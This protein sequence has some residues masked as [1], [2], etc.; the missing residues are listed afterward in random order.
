MLRAYFRAPT[1]IFLG[2]WLVLMLAGR[3]RFF[4]DPGAMWHIVV[5]QHI[6]SQHE[7]PHTDPFS[8][9]F[10]GQ[11]WIAQWWVGECLLAFLHQIGG[12]DTVLLVT[13]ALLAWL[14]AWLGHR[15]IRGGM[16]PLI[17][18]LVVALTFLGSSYHFHPRP[19]LLTIALVGWTFARLCDV[20]AGRT[21]LLNLFWLVP[22]YVVWANVHGGMVGGV[23][24]L[25]AATIG[26]GVARWLCRPTPLTSYRQLA[27][28]GALVLACGLAALVNPY[29][30]ALP[31]V[32]LELM[33]SSLLPR[34]M[35]E[36][37]PLLASGSVAWTV[38]LFGL[39]YLAVL[40]GVPWR[41]IR[42]TWLLPLLWFALAWTRIRHGPLFVLTAALAIGEM[43]PLVRWREWLVRI[44]S[45]TC[46]LQP[47]DLATG[48]RSRWK[49]AVF[50]VLLLLTGLTLEAGAVRVPVLGRGWAHLDPD[51]CPVA[52]LPELQDQ[53]QT[54]PRKRKPI[55]N[56]MIFGGFLIY[57]TPNLSVFIDDRC[58]LYGDRWLEQYAEAYYHQPAMIEDWAR[59]YGFDRA[60]VI[61]DS[62]FDKYLRDAK[63]WAVVQRTASAVLYRQV[64]A[65]G[66]LPDRGHEQSHASR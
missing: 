25:A 8:C 64:P 24:T 13:T 53:D 28:L 16:H 31:R 33:G 41:Q 4:A 15:L 22:L 9:T 11:P 29:G 37:G 14:Y 44:G 18:V 35:Q 43:Y 50:P 34:I 36:H 48:A 6:L 52:L 23:G 54:G 58:E 2:L 26:W 17:A 59:E 55:F 47:V 46:R 12:L 66:S 56:D 30:L 5:G 32:W 38:F 20:E 3:S 19:H 63:G 42:V 10:G 21:S 49:M 7:L 60:L 62:T 65:S 27:L 45:V 39:L 51:S 57:C 1:L 40:V 61:P